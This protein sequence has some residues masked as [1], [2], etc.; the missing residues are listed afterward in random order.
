MINMDRFV[1]I[2]FHIT[3]MYACSEKIFTTGVNCEE[4]YQ[5]KPDSA[6]LVIELTINDIYDSIPLTIY[7]DE[8]ENNDIEWIDTAYANPFY[9]LVPVNKEFS[10]AAEYIKSAEKIIAIDGTKI[11]IKH[12]SG[13]CDEDCWIIE[14]DDLNVKLKYQ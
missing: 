10:V 2:L 4:C 13:E 12:V 7:K 11:R 6:Y 8:V 14:G 5:E 9:L 3:L 1:I